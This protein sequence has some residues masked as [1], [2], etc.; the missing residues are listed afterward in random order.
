MERVPVWLERDLAGP[1]VGLGGGEYF[2]KGGS[3]G[4]GAYA[5]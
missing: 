3:S 5:G 4:V 2:P 1:K